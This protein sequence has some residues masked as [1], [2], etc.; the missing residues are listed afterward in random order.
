M[1]EGA[2]S[3]SVLA[4]VLAA[5]SLWAG[6]AQS[7][8]N[9]DFG[10]NWSRV[11]TGFAATGQST[12]DFW[13][14]WTHPWEN[15]VETKGLR[16]AE[17]KPTSVDMTV[18]NA[19]GQWNNLLADVMYDSYVYSHDRSSPITVTLTNLPPGMYDLYLYGHAGPALPVANS[20][21]QVLGGVV[22]HGS[23]A[24][25]QLANWDSPVWQEGRQY[26][27]FRNVRPGPGGSLTVLVYKDGWI[28]PYLNGM[29]IVQH[30]P[31]CGLWL[32]TTLTNR[33]VDQ[34]EDVTFAVD[35]VSPLP[36]RYQWSH[37]G[38]RIPGA[39]RRSLTLPAASPSEAGEYKVTVTSGDCVVTASASLGFKLQSP[40]LWNLD[41]GVGP[42][43]TGYAATGQSEM[44]QWNAVGA[45]GGANLVLADGRAS[46]AGAHLAN[47]TIVADNLAADEMYR[48][49]VTAT[50]GA[51]PMTLTITNLP[52]GIYDFYLYGHGAGGERFN[53][54]FELAAGGV[55]YGRRATD[56]SLDWQ[57]PAWEEWIQY[58]A[59]RAV[60]IP[61]EGGPVVIQVAGDGGPQG[62]L[63]GLQIVHR[64]GVRLDE[65]LLSQTVALETPVT[66][67]VSAKSE[68]PVTYQ[69]QL[70]GVDI[71]HATNRTLRL[72]AI[73]PGQAGAYSVKVSN[74]DTTL[75][76][77]ARVQFKVL[78]VATLPVLTIDAPVGSR[79]QVQYT[80]DSE[81]GTNWTSLGTVVLPERPYLYV[82]RSATNGALRVYRVLSVP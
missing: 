19:A 53:S 5:F 9:V 71:P 69:W 67:A 77:E 14:V 3:R 68:F 56:I 66:L 37:G 81:G 82:D 30:G 20:I 36:V 22:D 29:Q 75:V 23:K 6:Q 43:K 72:P 49:Y 27:V 15:F 46:T 32:G 73:A 10:E 76:A 70:N 26:V 38:I 34:G 64:T 62:A 8:W 42:A 47:A 63:S 4:F 50:A 65:T 13:N 31:D 28:E 24:T 79:W 58:V 1:Y 59:F 74:G 2:N 45:T 57:S 25:T 60:T 41:F 78:S 39:T 17:G 54:L 80:E 18:A 48:S 52:P 21:F 7:L 33:M 44:D 35:A 11:Q 40:N 16:T 51:G 12:A 55:S 61:A